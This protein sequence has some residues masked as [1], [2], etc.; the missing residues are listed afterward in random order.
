MVELAA[1]GMATADDLRSLAA[2]CR[3]AVIRQGFSDWPAVAA[4]RQSAASALSH[5][6]RFAAGL[7]AEYFTAGAELSGNVYPSLV[8]FDNSV[9]GGQS[10]ASSFTDILGGEE[11]F[12]DM[13]QMLR[14]NSSAVVG[15]AQGY[16][17]SRAGFFML[18]SLMG[19]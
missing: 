4:G 11:G 12:K 19:V 5:I 14:G 7:S 6:A 13:R 9:D 2:L 3:P 17:T 10:Q 1:A 16:K 18:A 15:D 8:L